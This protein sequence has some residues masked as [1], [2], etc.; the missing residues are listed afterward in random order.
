M[1]VVGAGHVVR[2]KPFTQSMAQLAHQGAGADQPDLAF[3]PVRHGQVGRFHNGKPARV[4]NCGQ[5]R[6]LLR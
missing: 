4:R 2:W 3:Q 6:V 5:L 1:S